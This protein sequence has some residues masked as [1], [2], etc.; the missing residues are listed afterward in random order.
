MKEILENIQKILGNEYFNLSTKNQ[1]IVDG[2]INSLQNVPNEIDTEKIYNIAGWT[3]GL[4]EAKLK[5]KSMEENTEEPLHKHEYNIKMIK[6][7]IRMNE[8]WIAES[9]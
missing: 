9:K 6:K 2:L 4:E 7:L 5:L 8:R 3:V 1:R